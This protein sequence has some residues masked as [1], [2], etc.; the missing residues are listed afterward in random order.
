MVCC[1]W[2]ILVLIIHDPLHLVSKHCGHVL[3]QQCCKMFVGKSN[4]CF[5]CE[6]KC[7]EKD[8]VEIKVE[9]TGFAA[10]GKAEGIKEGLAFQ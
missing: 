7:K 2:R 5:V 4:K 9:G 10:G 8:L 3:C 6:G 1:V